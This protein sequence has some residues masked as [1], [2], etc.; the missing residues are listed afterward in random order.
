MKLKHTT[1]LIELLSMLND[2]VMA[3]LGL[4]ETEI[5]SLDEVFDFACEHY[6]SVVGLK[7]P[8]E[9]LGGEIT[10]DMPTI[11]VL[12]PGSSVQ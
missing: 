6:E 12:R 3:D 11:F 9:G 8:L 10:A 2:T 7:H 1:A 4:T 5:E